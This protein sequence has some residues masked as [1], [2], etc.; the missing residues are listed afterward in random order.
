MIDLNNGRIQINTKWSKDNEL[1]E[2]SSIGELNINGNEIIFNIKDTVDIFARNFVGSSEGNIFKVF[3]YGQQ[4]LDSTGCFYRVSKACLYNGNNYA[5]DKYDNV[6]N[7]IESF[8]F[9]IPELVHWLKIPSVEF[10]ILDDQT[11]I[12]HELETPIIWLKDEKVKVYI[13]YENKNFWEGISNKNEMTLRKKPRIFVEFEK[14]ENDM[15]VVNYI[16]ILT[17]FF[18]ML[19]GKVS[20][21]IDIRLSTKSEKTSMWLFINEDFSVNNE[22][23]LYSISYRT[24]Y[25]EVSEQLKVW[26]ETWYNFSIDSSF[27][28]LQNYFFSTCSKKH[29]NIEELF[30]IYIKFVEGYDLRVSKDEEKAKEL[31]I[32]L[33]GI[34]NN[35]NIKEL[36]SPEF[37]NVGSKYKAKDVAKWISNGFLGRVALE[38]RIRRIDKNFFN[39]I[40]SNSSDVIEGISSNDLY[41]KITKTRNYYSHFKPDSEGILEMK[42]IYNLIPIMKFMI[43]IILLSHMGLDNDIIRA[44]IVKD[45][46]FWSFTK[47]LRKDT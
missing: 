5:Y 15:M 40:S 6:I 3:T 42:E 18:S 33:D 27:M 19:I 38:D 43:T 17:R 9:E 44:I 28:F 47:H 16:R 13:K 26:F 30:L 11:A 34:M 46:V 12:I 29:W 25:K 14:A 41:K 35:Q 2:D 8:S 39:I 22:V 31:L 7:E 37:K 45:D 4:E 36:L 20:A 21:A 10:G 24:E 1:K 23:N 32:A